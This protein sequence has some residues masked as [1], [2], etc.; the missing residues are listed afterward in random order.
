MPV[1]CIHDV[2]ETQNKDAGSM[3]D[4]KK[5][6]HMAAG[7]DDDYG[8]GVFDVWKRLPPP[9]N[10]NKQRTAVTS[11]DKREINSRDRDTCRER[12]RSAERKKETRQIQRPAGR[13]G[14]TGQT[15]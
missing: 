1:Y 2:Q 15:G 7:E 13:G 5:K 9:L 11:A 6:A 4:R 12:R 14:G 10:I 8:R 3:R